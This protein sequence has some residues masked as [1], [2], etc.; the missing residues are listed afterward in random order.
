[1]LC[2]KVIQAFPC[3]YLGLPLHIRALR[4]IDVQPL[5]DKVAARLPTW[6]G[7]LMN[8]SERVVL[9]NK[10]LSSIPVYFLSVIPLK[11][12][13]IKKIDKV[14]RNFLW[15]GEIEANGG[16]CLVKWTNVQK[17][18]DY[19]GLGTLELEKFGRALRLRWIW[20]QWVD[21]NR[22]WEGSE[23]PVN[24]VDL[25]LFRASTHMHI[26]NGQRAEFWN[27]YG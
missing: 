3:T 2:R 19:G 13:A 18:K 9:L 21:P 11:R 7:R 25:Q 4:R 14:R 6:K 20:Q 22:P 27:A 26:G 17:P 24:E 23:A 12:W 8:K 15:K 1:M 5:I 16:H 10:L